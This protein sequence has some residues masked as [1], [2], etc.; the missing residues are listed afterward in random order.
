MKAGVVGI[1]K[2]LAR[3]CAEVGQTRGSEYIFFGI[4]E[5]EAY[6]VLYRTIENSAGQ[7][8]GGKGVTML[9]LVLDFVKNSRM[10]F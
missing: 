1:V 5:C 3:V 2:V 9:C 8:D 6:A 7:I 4:P 10:F